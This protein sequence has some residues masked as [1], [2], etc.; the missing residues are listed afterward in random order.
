[1]SGQVFDDPSAKWF[2]LQDRTEPPEDDCSINSKG[3]VILAL[4]YVPSDAS[5]KFSKKRKGTLMVKITEAKNLPIPRGTALPDPYCK[6]Y[7]LPNHPRGKQKTGVCRKTTSPR[8]DQTLSWEDLSIEDLA[9]R[10]FELAV[11]D[12]DRLGHQDFLGGVRLNLGSGKHSG[13]ST[14]WMDAVGKEVTLWQQML[15]RPN[16]CHVNFQ[17]HS[18]TLL[19]FIV[20]CCNEI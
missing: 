13:R 9:D 14:S 18:V 2:S 1:M 17:I 3:D 16:L 15:D 6:C 11:W 10:S 4:K 20:V 19:L 12:H 7:L 5:L 8:W